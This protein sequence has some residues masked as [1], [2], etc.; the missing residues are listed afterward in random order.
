MKFVVYIACC[1]VFA[2]TSIAQQRLEKESKFLI[3]DVDAETLT[4]M[5]DSLFAEGTL[6]MTETGIVNR[7]TTELFTDEYFDSTNKQLLNRNLSLRYRE[8]KQS[9]NQEKKLVQFKGLLKESSGIQ[10]EYKFGVPD[11][12]DRNDIYARHPVLGR[13]DKDERERFEYEL[14]RFDIATEGLQSAFRFDQKRQRWYLSDSKGDMLTVSLD[15]V[16]LKSIPFH[17]FTE[18]EIEINE[19]RYTNGNE[20]ERAYLDTIQDK[21]VHL[22]KLDFPFMEAD[23]RSKYEKMQTLIEGS[24]LSKVKNSFVWLLYGAIVLLS[25]IKFKGL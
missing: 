15:H 10:F 2:T 12:P 9:E 14:A 8:R 5:L 23:Q 13:V 20:A 11:V 18:L 25:A 16:R 17:A 21:L 4:G 7:T 24:L 19:N 6:F 22:K 1:L 3:A